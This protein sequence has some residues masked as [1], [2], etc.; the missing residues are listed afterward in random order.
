MTKRNPNIRIHHHSL[1]VLDEPERARATRRGEIVHHALG[2]LGTLS[3]RGAIP[4]CGPRGGFELR[5]ET[6]VI[7]AFAALNLD[8]GTWSIADDFVRP[9]VKVFQLDGFR[10]WFGEAA[11]SLS[12]NEIM[13]AEGDVHRPDR[14]VFK[15]GRIEVID[16][17]VG[18][19]EE[20][21]AVQVRT[22]VGLLAEVFEGTPVAGFLVYIDEPAIVEVR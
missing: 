16:F 18:R 8:P 11:I 15:N 10:A 17:K 12:E 20:S 14:V 4:H 1:S 19:R 3:E 7:K 2:L 13:D 9:L 6:S 22:Y 5:I 21:H